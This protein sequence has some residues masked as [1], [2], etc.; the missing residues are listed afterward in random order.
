[1]IPLWNHTWNILHDCLPLGDLESEDQVKEVVLK[2]GGKKFYYPLCIPL[3]LFP[4][5]LLSSLNI[6]HIVIG[7][8]TAR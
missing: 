6:K 7:Q 4:P 2:N 1:M 3:F 8:K 5:F